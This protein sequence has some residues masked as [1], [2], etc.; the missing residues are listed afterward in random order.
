MPRW[1]LYCVLALLFFGGWAAGPKTVPHIPSFEL[2]ALSTVGLLPILAVLGL[3]RKKLG[4]G[5]S[6]RKGALL[7]FLAGL[8]AAGGN[9]AYF[10]AL[11]RGGSAMTVAPLTALYPLVT[12]VLAL[13]FLR[14]KPR[15][16]QVFG[17]AVAL[18]AIYA[19]NPEGEGADWRSLGFYMLLPIGLWGVSA[20]LQKLST[21]HASS[22]LSA[23]WFQAA[24]LPAAGV[25]LAILL[26][27][28]E[29]LAALSARD[30]AMV[31]LIGLLFGLGNLALIAAYGS[32]GKA[33][34]VT[35]L[36]GLY[37]V[38][39]VPLAML[40]GERAGIREAAGIGLALAAVT[41]LSCE[42]QKETPG[43]AP[44]P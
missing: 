19:F 13:V 28:G 8:L 21:T 40:L 30:W 35:P 1:L 25:I 38:V 36:S 3:S 5:S 14:E 18:S 17:I 20:L 12:V 7:A 22:E 33:S 26:G 16:I 31:S 11:R 2:L 43:V 39:T 15:P 34:I 44:V 29:V 23:F 32:G 6:K 41:L 37:S 42:R 24:F 10:E 4:Q 9:I 27:R